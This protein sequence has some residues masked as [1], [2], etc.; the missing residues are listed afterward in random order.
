MATVLQVNESD[1]R[2][3]LGRY[4]YIGIL[5]K[6]QESLDLFASMIGKKSLRM[7]FTNRTRV[8]P[9]TIA[10][11]LSPE[12]I[13]KFR[14]INRLDY[15]IYDYCLERFQNTRQGSCPKPEAQTTP[16]TP[17]PHSQISP[18]HRG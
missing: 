7:P 13:A 10:N 5:E 18:F 4:F 8:T 1:Y 11:D 14:E 15:L 6:A 17:V 12:L 16:I 9:G 2:E 3:V